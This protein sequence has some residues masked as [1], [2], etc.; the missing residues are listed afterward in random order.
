MSSNATFTTTVGILLFLV[1]CGPPFDLPEDVDESFQETEPNDS[2]SDAE[3]TGFELDGETWF[4]LNGTFDDEND[5]DHFRLDLHLSVVE[6]DMVTF[7]EFEGS[8]QQYNMLFPV[9]VLNEDSQGNLGTWQLFAAGG[10][11]T[12]LD[13][14]ARSIVVRV[15]GKEATNSGTDSFAPYMG[16]KP[17]RVLIR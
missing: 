13:V 6:F 12:E 3:D 15:Y 16:G 10:Y 14:A 17:Y 9:D 8:E 2:R 1:G 4:E 7:R 5:E 11:G